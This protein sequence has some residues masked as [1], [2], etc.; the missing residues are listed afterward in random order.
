MLRERLPDAQKAGILPKESPG[1][2]Q[3][4]LEADIRKYTALAAAKKAA[5]SD[6][7]KPMVTGK[8]WKEHKGNFEKDDWIKHVRNAMKELEPAVAL[9]NK[10]CDTLNAMHL[11]SIEK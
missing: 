8:S 11:A 7:V 2:Y 5:S 10:K 1:G 3:R 6:F 4:S 9:L